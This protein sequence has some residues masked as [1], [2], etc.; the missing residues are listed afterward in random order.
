MKNTVVFYAKPYVNLGVRQAM[1][2]DDILKA[3]ILCPFI[4]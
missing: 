4:H 3:D 1:A 2:A